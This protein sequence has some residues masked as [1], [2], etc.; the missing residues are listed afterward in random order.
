MKYTLQCPACQSNNTSLLI[1]IGYQP[2]SLVEL[3]E[4]PDASYRATRR[5][6]RMQICRNCSHVFNSAFEPDQAYYEGMG[7]RMYNAGG[8]WQDHLQSVREKLEPILLG[9]DVAVEIGAGDCEF[10]DSLNTDAIKVAVDPCEAVERAEELGIQYHRTMFSYK[11]HVPDG[12]QPLI[13]ARH[14]LE[15]LQAPRKLL[16]EIATEARKR[17]KTTYLYL[18]VPNCEVALNNTRIEDWTY[19][20]VQHFTIRSMQALLRNSGI[21]HFVITKRYGDEVLSVIAKID[22]VTVNP[23]DLDVDVVLDNYTHA[24]KIVDTENVR[25]RSR[26]GQVAFWGG[27]G[28][29]AM[30]INLFDLPP[31]ACV[32]DSHD[33]KWGMC[34][35]GTRIKIQDPEILKEFCPHY[36]VATTSW[37]AEDIRDEIK[38]R[39][40]KCGQLLKFQN[41]QLTEVPLG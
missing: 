21:D 2:M 24:A 38:R 29:S 1:D 19:E 28:K 33:E 14:L 25:I 15:H 8:R 7:C 22:P 39:G 31:S 17:S 18:E 20:H 5:V 11:H 37:R 41:G 36:I 13:L 34:V 23:A 30:F 9:C 27:A 4:D 10:L 32:V 16:E 6:I 35:P 26:L 12:G 40:I 3:Q